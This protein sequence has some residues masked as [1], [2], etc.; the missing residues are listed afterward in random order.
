MSNIKIALDNN[1]QI[2][3][4]HNIAFCVMP[5]GW[6]PFL[7]IKNNTLS[8]VKKQEV[9]DFPTQFYPNK[10][11]AQD[12]RNFDL[13]VVGALGYLD[14]GFK[15]Y[16]TH[17]PLASG[18]LA[19]GIP[20]FDTKITDIF[21][22]VLDLP[23]IS[24]DVYAEI[25]KNFFLTKHGGFK[26]IKDL[27]KNFLKKIILIRCPKIA[28]F[29]KNRDDWL[30]NKIYEKPLLAHE[31]FEKERNK[32]LENFASEN[33]IELLKY[34]KEIN[35]SLLFTPNHLMNQKD[36]LHFNEIYGEYLLRQI[37]DYATKLK[38]N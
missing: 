1:K 25:I 35:S 21:N 29:I 5:G 11:Y 22:K 16:A 38:I 3:K 8:P 27:K 34:P 33:D 2:S 10:S 24:K 14:G 37:L 23:L 4:I 7:N 18:A 6:G 28:D 32:F 12:L 13:I 19:E 20:K 15:Y 31:F 26:F 36:G 30:L 9:K 17:S